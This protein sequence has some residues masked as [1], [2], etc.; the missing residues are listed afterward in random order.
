MKDSKNMSKGLA[1]KTKI[2]AD[3]TQSEQNPKQSTVGLHGIF[4][5]KS[6]IRASSS[7]Q[8]EFLSRNSFNNHDRGPGPA[9]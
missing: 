2:L 6:I 7:C 3:S 1:K 8:L 5:A 9:C 4:K